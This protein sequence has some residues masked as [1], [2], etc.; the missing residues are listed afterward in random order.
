MK[1]TMAV[2]LLHS[3]AASIMVQRIFCV[4]AFKFHNCR[5]ISTVGT[6]AYSYVVLLLYIICMF[7][8]SYAVSTN[9]NVIEFFAKHGYLWMVVW[10]LD[11]IFTKLSFIFIIIC[12]E[13]NKRNHIRFY[14]KMLAID[15]FFRLRFE[16]TFNYDRLRR[17]N[18]LMTGLCLL[19]SEGFT[20]FATYK[21]WTRNFFP[22]QGLIIFA[23]AYQFD[24]MAVNL[25]TWVYI[26]HVAMI[27]CRFKRL[28][29]VTRVMNNRRRFVQSLKYGMRQ[30]VTPMSG[31]LV[32]KQLLNVVTILNENSE[33][34]FVRLIHDFIVTLTQ[35]YMLIWLIIDKSGSDRYPSIITAILFIVHSLIRIAMT[36]L[37]TQAAVAEVRKIQNRC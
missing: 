27:R 31:L 24:Q 9:S 33:S 36:T 12:S 35:F 28:Q 19:Y 25:N 20:A 8:N 29:E 23:L 13:L 34:I 4:S 6:M 30:V 2:T 14:E 3:F 21:M 11:L 37:A 17:T 5:L 7:L 15:E 26:S 1:A 32:Y 18:L 22:K 10:M 16:T